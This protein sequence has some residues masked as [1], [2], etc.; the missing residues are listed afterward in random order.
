ML[1]SIYKDRDAVIYYYYGAIGY[2]FG[3]IFVLFCQNSVAYPTPF[4]GG[5]CEIYYMAMY[6]S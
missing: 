2:Y 6:G 1:S 5:R 3:I 4:F